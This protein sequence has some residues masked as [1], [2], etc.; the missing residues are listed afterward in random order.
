MTKTANLR[1]QHEELA[2]LAGAMMQQLP[3]VADA[4]HAEEVRK[5]LAR[6]AGKLQVHAA[7]EDRAVYPRLVAHT[8][9]NIRQ[10][11]QQLHDEFG[12]IYQAVGA[13]TKRWLPRGA[14]ERSADRFAVETRGIVDALTQRIDAENEQLYD[15]LD[16][17]E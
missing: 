15:V 3:H 9:E 12:G 8:D 13:W 2:A 14:L 5:L 7:M 10:T 16:R 1:R 17:L 11:A 6:F 4:E